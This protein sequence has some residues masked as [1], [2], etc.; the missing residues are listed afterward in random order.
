MLKVAE[1]L[2]A[3]QRQTMTGED[4]DYFDNLDGNTVIKN[5]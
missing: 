3:Y 5:R 4:Q 2:V 1:D